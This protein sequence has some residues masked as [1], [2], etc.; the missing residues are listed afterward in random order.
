MKSKLLDPDKLDK[1]ED[2]EGNNVAFRCPI[3]EKV[4]IVSALIHR[5]KRTCP[6]C[7]KST[8]FCSSKGKKSGGTARIEW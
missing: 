2:W 8:G 5:G 1:N 3:C 7:K 4:F 6:D